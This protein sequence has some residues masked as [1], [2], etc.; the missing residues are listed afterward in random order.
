[1]V[2]ILCAIGVAVDGGARGDQFYH[3]LGYALSQH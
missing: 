2:T 1:M 3:R